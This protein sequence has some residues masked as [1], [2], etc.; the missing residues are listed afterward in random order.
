M[1]IEKYVSLKNMDTE[2]F[3]PGLP[4]PATDL[5]LGHEGDAAD[6]PG[7]K[8]HPVIAIVDYGLGNVRA[9]AHIYKNL[10]VPCTLAASAGEL[11]RATGLILPGVGAFDHAMEMLERSGLRGKLEELVRDRRV[12]VLGVCLGMQML[13]RSSEEGRRP[14]LGWI[15]GEVKK[16]RLPDPPGGVRLPHMGWNDVTPVQPG[17]LFSGLAE[18]AV[19]YFLHS[20]YFSCDDERDAVAVTEYGLR[21]ACAVNSGRVYGVQFH[22]EKSHR[23]G[24][25]LLENFASLTREE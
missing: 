13:A 24:I 19:F 7:A 4:F 15:A 3:V 9:F 10:N 18:G 17:G 22:P 2:A 12:P 8:G 14:G 21:F 1:V 23:Q 6:R 20:Y 25:R 5:P 11:E 16:L